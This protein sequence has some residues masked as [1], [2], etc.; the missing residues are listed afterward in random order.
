[1]FYVNIYTNPTRQRIN[2]HFRSNESNEIELKILN[3]MSQILFLDNFKQFKE[4]YLNEILIDKY[5]KGIY[6]FHIM[7][8]LGVIN[9]NVINQ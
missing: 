3:N 6:Y 4:D 5:S 2:I 9:M 8:N 7:T 1:M